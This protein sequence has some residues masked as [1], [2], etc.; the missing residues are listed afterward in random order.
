VAER[1]A[2]LPE[3][4]AKSYTAG[5]VPKGLKAVISNTADHCGAKPEGAHIEN[6]EGAVFFALCEAAGVRFCEIRSISN[7]AGAARDEWQTETATENLARILSETFVKRGIM[8]KTKIILWIAAAVILIALLALAVTKWNE[9]FVRIMTWVIVIAVS[10]CAGWLTGR[11]A[12]G[13]KRTPE[14]R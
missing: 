4:Y 6:M 11:F 7:R 12:G 13:K 9:W 10:F 1:S 3:S 8:N 2:S 5:F 14:Q